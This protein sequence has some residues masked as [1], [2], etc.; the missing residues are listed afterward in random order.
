MEDNGWAE[1]VIPPGCFLPVNYAVFETSF[2]TKRTINTMTIEIPQPSSICRIS[3]AVRSQ[4]VALL[5]R[6]IDDYAH[7]RNG[8]S[9]SNPEFKKRSCCFHGLL[10]ILTDFFYLHD[11][12]P[13][14]RLG[15]D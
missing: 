6:N 15:D 2:S 8:Y 10:M 9:Q 13:C 5:Y 4:T 11:P 7:Q 14:L 1:I 12:S 3:K